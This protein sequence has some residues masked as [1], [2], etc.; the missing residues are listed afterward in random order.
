VSAVWERY[1]PAEELRALVDGGFGAPGP[2]GERPALMVI[3]VVE[4]FLGDGGTGR[5]GM[6]CGP[7][8]R[9][10]LPAICTLIDAARAARVPVVFTKGD[11]VDKAFAGGSIKRTRDGD[12]ARAVHDS[13]FPPEIVPRPDEYVLSKP[14]ASAFFG[15]PL[16]SYLQRCGIDS[17]VLAGT[18][19]SGCIRATA[20]DAASY[21]YAVVAVEDACFD[22]S[23]FAHA[24]NLFDIQM[25]Y[26]EVVDAAAARAL[27]S[28]A[29][30]S[31]RDS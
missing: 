1:V 11:P 31:R 6:G 12:V 20:V 22:R 24:A 4:S 7:M 16:V 3:D 13:P 28:S 23:H 10:R 30:G 19:T 18:T 8:G 17:L 2:R 15:T 25:K 14:K 21:N 9:E 26:G 5:L 29:A 27:L